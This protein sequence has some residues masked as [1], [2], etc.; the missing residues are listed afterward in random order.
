MTGEGKGVAAVVSGIVHGRGVREPSPEDN[1]NP[2]N[3]GQDGR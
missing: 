1:E 3:Y 2:E